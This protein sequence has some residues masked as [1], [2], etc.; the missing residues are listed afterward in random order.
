MK[1]IKS[2]LVFSLFSGVFYFPAVAVAEARAYPL[3]MKLIGLH[4]PEAASIKRL[5]EK[6][7]MQLTLQVFSRLGV[8]VELEY[9]PVAKGFAALKNG[10]Y[11]AMQGARYLYSD[12]VKQRLEIVPIRTYFV[13]AYYF[14][15][16]PMPVQEQLGRGVLA[17]KDVAGSDR[18][19]RVEQ[20]LPISS[21]HYLVDVPR[22]FDLLKIGRLDYGFVSDRTGDAYVKELGEIEG[23]R[24]H[25]LLRPISATSSGV[26]FDVSQPGIPAL[27]KAFEAELEEAMADPELALWVAANPSTFA[28]PLRPAPFLSIAD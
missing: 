26:V 12:A 13:S 24:F 21:F 8:D 27:T 9:L 15:A 11:P 16:E 14:S 1:H 6:P 7:A 3:S 20:L 5:R 23:G 10:K 4:Y 19:S 18:S 2:L 22:I 25:K 17:G 28:Q